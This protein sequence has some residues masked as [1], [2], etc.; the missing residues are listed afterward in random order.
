MMMMIDHDQDEDSSLSICQALGYNA[1][2]YLPTL[3][4]QTFMWQQVCA[5]AKDVLETLEI[6]EEDLQLLTQGGSLSELQVSRP[7]HPDSASARSVK[8][9][10]AFSA[11]T[12]SVSCSR[13]LA[14]FDLHCVRV[15][16]LAFVVPVFIVSALVVDS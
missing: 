8:K 7:T 6:D 16:A 14:H 1:I 5:D 11:S 2:L 15:L 10:Y 12:I 9:L 13:A 3:S 4:S